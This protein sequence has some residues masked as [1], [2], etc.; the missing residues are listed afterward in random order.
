MIFN[1]EEARTGL[2]N[3]VSA[4]FS[5]I[6][7]VEGHTYTDEKLSFLLEDSSIKEVVS[8]YYMARIVD[9]VEFI[10]DYKFKKSDI[11]TRSWKFVLTDPILEENQG[12]FNL[13]IDK[14]GKAHAEKIEEHCDDEISIQTMTTMLMGYKRP[15]YLY[16]IGRIKADKEIVEMLE[17]SITQDV[18]YISDYF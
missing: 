3:F 11:E 16:K 9:F 12:T 13:I 10:K 4:H 1:N 5:M 18:P 15:E 17:N 2:W 6:D 7:K 8:P 14:N